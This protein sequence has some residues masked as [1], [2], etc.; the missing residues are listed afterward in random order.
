LGRAGG[1]NAVTDVK[2][3]SGEGVMTVTITRPE[4]RNAI[5]RSVAEGIAAAVD[6]LNHRPCRVGASRA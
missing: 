2:V 3:E 4:A 6:E 1:E 5:N